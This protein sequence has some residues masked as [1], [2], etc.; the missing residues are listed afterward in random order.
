VPDN[1]VVKRKV[2]VVDDD[3]V[4]LDLTTDFMEDEG[5]E[6]IKAYDGEEGFERAK[7]FLPDLIITDVMMPKMD[8]FTLCKTLKNEEKT[9]NIP[10]L[11]LTGKI[12]TEEVEK[13]FELGAIDCIIKPP[14]WDVLLKKIAHIMKK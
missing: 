5:Y 1:N 14:N 4:L 11:I 9:K 10:V 8:G 3:V 2:L 7:L 6:V 13:S 12:G